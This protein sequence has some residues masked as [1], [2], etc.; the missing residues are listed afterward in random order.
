MG[1]AGATR[2]A[3]DD[4]SQETLSQRLCRPIFAAAPDTGQGTCLTLTQVRILAE[5]LHTPDSCSEIQSIPVHDITV[6]CSVSVIPPLRLTDSLLADDPEPDSNINVADSLDTSLDDDDA[7]RLEHLMTDKPLPNPFHP[8]PDT[9]NE[10]SIAKSLAMQS[11][12]PPPNL[13]Y[14]SY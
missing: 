9:M 12:S 4:S 2:K 14:K 10:L 7:E 1:H 6:F 5:H 11:A 8:T 13:R 3:P